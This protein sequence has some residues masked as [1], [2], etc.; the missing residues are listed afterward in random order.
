MEL[1]Q[2]QGSWSRETAVITSSDTDHIRIL[3]VRYASLKMKSKYNFGKIICE[4]E[5]S[6]YICQ[7]FFGGGGTIQH[8]E[9]K[10]KPNGLCVS[11]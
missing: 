6:S 9:L 7:V 1:N 2:F 8:S 3:T 10:N 4:D 5:T 11:R